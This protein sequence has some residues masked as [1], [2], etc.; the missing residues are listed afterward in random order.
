MLPVQRSYVLVC[1]W[2]SQASPV[3]WH[4]YNHGTHFTLQGS[5]GTL[6]ILR[7]DV[8]SSSIVVQAV[9]LISALPILYFCVR[10]HF[11]KNLLNS[12]LSSHLN[13][14]LTTTVLL[15]KWQS[16]AS[17]RSLPGSRDLFPCAKSPGFNLTHHLIPWRSFRFWF[18]HPKCLLFFLTLCCL[19]IFNIGQ[20]AT[21][22]QALFQG[23]EQRTSS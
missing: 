12:L 22:C 16:Q 14:P 1:P 20:T 23:M 21:A 3:A 6:I 15:V 2:R 18:Y 7:V 11:V 10:H 9:S 19:Y 13:F 4:Y 8:G 5:D 17:N